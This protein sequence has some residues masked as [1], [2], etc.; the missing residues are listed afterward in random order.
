ML[1]AGCYQKGVAGPVNSLA[2]RY[3]SMRISKNDN[4]ALL[5][6]IPNNSERKLFVYFWGYSMLSPSKPNDV[7]RVGEEMQ[8]V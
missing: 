5:T 1:C 8:C 3:L 6:D 7:K 4:S 2:I